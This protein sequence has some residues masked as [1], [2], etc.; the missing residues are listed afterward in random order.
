MNNYS[1]NRVKEPLIRIVKRDNTTFWYRFGVRC[2]A[3]GASVVL[4][5]LLTLIL[6]GLSVGKIFEYMFTR[7]FAN[8]ASF[9]DFLKD[10]CML[11]CISIALVPAFKM[12]FWNIGAQ[13]QVLMGAMCAACCTH[14]IG[15][16]VSET[17][18]LLIMFIAG[19]LGGA[20]WAF[21][22]AIFKVK[23]G[24]NETLFT[25]MMNYVA[26]QIV[27]CFI[28]SWK[29]LSPTLGMFSEGFLPSLFGVK[30]M[31][32]YLIL[33]ALSIFIYIYMSKTK[34]GYEIA[35]VGESMSTAKYAG[36]N[37]NKITLRTIAFSGAICGLCGFLY[38]SSTHTIASS[39]GGGYGFTAII[40]SWGAQ[41]NP[42]AMLG[43][44]A[45]IVFLEKGAKGII[46]KTNVFNDY[47]K[48]IYVAIFLL[49]L[50]GCE[51]FIK[52]KLI[53]RSKK[54]TVVEQGGKHE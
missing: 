49:F 23:I 8:E 37:T 3:I 50:I 42:L 48:N 5:I 33:I 2:A 32:I 53:F 30:Y 35:V 34:H 4:L 19:V 16:S 11:L 27:K 21:I 46:N 52:Y 54:N 12:K 22:P 51:F 10:V 47:L 13:G 29:G 28:D 17:A 40:V 1:A 36:M 24:S 7:I 38:V 43:I 15:T 14:Y 31:L 9:H 41:F 39:M 6:S 20:L 25:L 18:L 44:S 26:I 45:M